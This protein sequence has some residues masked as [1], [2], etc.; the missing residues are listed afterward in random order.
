MLLTVP[1]KWL[2]SSNDG[3][4]FLAWLLFQNYTNPTYRNAYTATAQELASK[5]AH[6]VKDNSNPTEWKKA[7]YASVLRHSGGLLY[8][9]VFFFYGTIVL[10]G[11]RIL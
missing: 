11:S 6:G 9:F 8:A 2:W 1:L 5:R 7:M 3:R 4:L 10:L